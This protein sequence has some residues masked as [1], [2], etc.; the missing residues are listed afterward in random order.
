M[1]MFSDSQR[2]R[3]FCGGIPAVTTGVVLLHC[4]YQWVDD[5]VCHL[6]VVSL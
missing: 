3:L 1:V 5:I 4:A 2:D 6:N